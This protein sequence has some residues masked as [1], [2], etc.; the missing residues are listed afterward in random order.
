MTIFSRIKLNQAAVLMIVSTFSALNIF[1]FLPVIIY[2]GNVSEFQVGLFDIVSHYIVGM[3]AFIVIVSSVGASLSPDKFQKFLSI[4]LALSVSAWVQASVINWQYGTFNGSGIDIGSYSWRGFLD[5]LLWISICYG[6]WRHRATIAKN[7]TFI[8]VLLITLQTIVI[9]FTLYSSN[10]I[11][12]KASSAAHPPSDLFSFS[13][14]HNIIHIVLD[15]FQSEVFT[16]I[17]RNNPSYSAKFDGFTFY[18]EATGVFPNTHMSIPAILSSTT[19]QNDQP[20]NVFVKKTMNSST[21]P[22]LLQQNGFSVDLAHHR[23]CFLDGKYNS[24][25]LIPIIYGTSSSEILSTTQSLIMLDLVLFRVSPHFLKKYIYN[26]ESWLLQR[27][28]GDNDS[29]KRRVFGQIEFLNDIT[30]YSVTNT[31]QDKY[32]FLHIMSSHPPYVLDKQFR[33]LGKSLPV[34]VEN[35]SHQCRFTLD[36]IVNFFNKLKKLGIYESSFIVIHADHGV[37]APIKGILKDE[38]VGGEDFQILAGSSTPLLLMKEPYSQGVIKISSSKAMLTDLPVTLASYYNIKNTF[39]GTPI[40]KL[41][42]VVPRDRLYYHH[43]WNRDFLADQYYPSLKEY[44][45]TG[46][47]TDPRAWTFVREIFPFIKPS[48][49]IKFGSA[50]T[51]AFLKDGWSGN[52]SSGETHESFNWATGSS[53]TIKAVLTPKKTTMIA[54]LKAPHFLNG[55]KQK[56]IVSIEGKDLG[57]F[58]LKR[59]WEWEQ[60]QVMI[61]PRKGLTD[62]TFKFSE[63]LPPNG[64]EKRWLAALFKEIRFDNTK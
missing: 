45:I 51:A 7:A 32:K 54:T 14:K 53:S 42:E 22:N 27:L 52:E 5:I 1:L 60:I 57:I 39:R 63:Q 29:L 48:T 44:K 9:T 46:K 47:A 41:D 58:E 37:R 55:K 33:Y 4:L 19:Y 64:K 59:E 62:I 31:D 20:I 38:K 35:A 11:A 56:V 34:T 8:S 10:T 49:V 12:I 43:I 2:S 36:A 25:Y 40:N 18:K 23:E 3:V 21:L 13:K 17:L 16:E 28:V 24:G 61:P 50:E 6:S 15:A 30:K 26:G